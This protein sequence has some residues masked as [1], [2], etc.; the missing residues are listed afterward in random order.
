MRRCYRLQKLLLVEFCM[1]L[2]D[3]WLTWQRCRIFGDPCFSTGNFLGQVSA[4]PI[5][6][7]QEVQGFALHDSC[8]EN[9]AWEGNFEH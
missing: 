6:L 5:K 7:P 3:S 9:G 8:F 2:F 1:G 4:G